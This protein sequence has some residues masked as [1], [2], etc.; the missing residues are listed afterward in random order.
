[1]PRPWRKPI[2]VAPPLDA[3]NRPEDFILTNVQFHEDGSHSAP[4]LR[5]PFRRERG[6]SVASVDH[7]FGALLARAK[8][9]R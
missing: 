6:L 9:P 4:W 3:R 1:M 8:E 7:D 2:D 5:Q